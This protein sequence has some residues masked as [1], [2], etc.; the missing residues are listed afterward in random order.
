M[1]CTDMRPNNRE[2]GWQDRVTPC[3]SRYRPVK[4]NYL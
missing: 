1:H 2:I 4:R 3:R